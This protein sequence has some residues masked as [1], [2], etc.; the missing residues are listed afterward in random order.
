MMRIDEC[1]TRSITMQ[2]LASKIGMTRA[3]VQAIK[4]GSKGQTLENLK[5]IADAL[6]CYPSDLLPLSWQ[7]PRVDLATMQPH[8]QQVLAVYET[9]KAQGSIPVTP[10]AASKIITT[11]CEHADITLPL[12][13]QEIIRYFQLL[14]TP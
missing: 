2:A 3:Y 14:A 4:S 10:L 5:R 7:R 12:D 13:D 1:N 11:L 9:L 8:A 6:D